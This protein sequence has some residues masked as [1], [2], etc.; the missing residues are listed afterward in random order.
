MV[1]A[2]WALGIGGIVVVDGDI[3]GTSS[4]VDVA[5]AVVLV[6][7][8]MDMDMGLVVLAVRMDSHIG[9]EVEEVVEGAVVE[10]N[11]QIA[12]ERW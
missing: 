1:E 12:H 3:R 9:S 5:V 8:D 4:L 6:G 11:M 2:G 10:A 7:M